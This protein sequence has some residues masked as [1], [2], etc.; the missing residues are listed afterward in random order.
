MKSLLFTKPKE[1]TFNCLKFLI[2]QKEEILGVVIPQK[3]NYLQS[4]FVLFCNKKKIKVFSNKE[5]YENIEKFNEL[6]VI[7]SNTFPYIIR[8]EIIIKAQ[9]YAINFHMAPLPKYRGVFGYNFAF[10]NN[11]NEYG[12]TV[13]HLNNSYDMGDIIEVLKFPYDCKTGSIKEL[14][15]LS[16]KY[17]FELFK[18]IYFRIKNNEKLKRIQQT[19]ENGKYYSRKDFERSKEISIETDFNESLEIK[20]KAFW[21]PPF[22]PAYIRINKKKYYLLN[23]EMYDDLKDK[24]D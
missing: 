3:E 16:D 23:E 7:Y 10:L 18:K 9:K 22:E 4:D 6:E 8:D 2:E 1:L 12:V 14:V 15:K 5:L 21:N 19:L 20:V 11:D 13:H 17:M 24:D